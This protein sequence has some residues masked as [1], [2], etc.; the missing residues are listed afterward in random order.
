[1]IKSRTVSTIPPI[2]YIYLMALVGMSALIITR[3]A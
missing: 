3:I 2:L 1:M